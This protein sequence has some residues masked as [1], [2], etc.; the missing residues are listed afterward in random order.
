MN[1]LDWSHNFNL[2]LYI[3]C[4][5]LFTFLPIADRAVVLY[6]SEKYG[7]NSSDYYFD[8]MMEPKKFEG[9]TDLVKRGL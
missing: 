2:E 8:P 3:L 4:S 9:W 5:N 7:I 6:G 1:N